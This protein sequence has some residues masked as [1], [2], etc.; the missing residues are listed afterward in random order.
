MGLGQPTAFER[1]PGAGAS[2]PFYMMGQCSWQLFFL[3]YHFPVIRYQSPGYNFVFQC[4]FSLS[5]KRLKGAWLFQKDGHKVAQL[6]SNCPSVFPPSHP[7]SPLATSVRRHCDLIQHTT[8][9]SRPSPSPVAARRLMR[10]LEKR[11]VDRVEYARAPLDDPLWN[12]FSKKL[13]VQHC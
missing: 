5:V 3:K 6:R 7:F 2:S 12:L 13:K 10:H 11:A 9:S 4:G 8:P 1:R